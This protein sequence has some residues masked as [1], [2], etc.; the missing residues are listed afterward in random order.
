MAVIASSSPLYFNHFALQVEQIY[1]QVLE[2]KNWNASIRYC[3]SRGMDLVSLESPEEWFQVAEMLRK[4]KSKSTTGTS[5]RTA[6]TTRRLG[7]Y[8]THFW[9][10]GTFDEAEEQWVWSSSG[11]ALNFTNWQRG[12]PDN[13]DVS[14]QVLII[15]GEEPFHWNDISRINQKNNRP[16]DAYFICES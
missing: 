15:R 7:Y 2:Q 10:A 8:G 3:K 5:Y 1:N 16:L 9:T 6:S 11:E 14:E 13:K 4:K 12:Q